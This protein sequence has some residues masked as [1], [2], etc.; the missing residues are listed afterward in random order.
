MSCKELSVIKLAHFEDEICADD[1]FFC[2]WIKY[3]FNI[4]YCEYFHEQLIDNL[5]SKT[6]PYLDMPPKRCDRCK[7][8]LG[9]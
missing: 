5:N 2:E 4:T 6:K 1:G 7:K 9:K 8:E 3:P